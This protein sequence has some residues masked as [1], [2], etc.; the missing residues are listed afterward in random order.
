VAR[1][2][3]TDSVSPNM[4]ADFS[5]WHDDVERELDLLDDTEMAGFDGGIEIR[6]EYIVPCGAI[7]L[8]LP[9]G[10]SN[11]GVVGRIG[12]ALD[13]GDQ[14]GLR[15]HQNLDRA[16]SF[17]GRRSVRPSL[18]GDFFIP[19]RPVGLDPGRLIIG[20]RSALFRDKTVFTFGLS[21]LA[22]LVQRDRE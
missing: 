22:G 6:R 15:S 3:G 21:F 10:P 1:V 20:Q 11:L 9:P 16:G 4:A 17:Y 7:L 8:G 12:R 2:Q 19:R 14:T 5:G 13:L 18:A